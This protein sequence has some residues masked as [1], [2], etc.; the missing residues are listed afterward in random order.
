MV[1]VTWVFH[2]FTPLL[3][4]PFIQPFIHLYGGHGVNTPG[5]AW[6]RG[7]WRVRQC[8]RCRGTA[9]CCGFG[10]G[11]AGEGQRCGTSADAGQELLCKSEFHNSGDRM[12]R[13]P[14]PL[15]G[16]QLHQGPPQARHA[17]TPTRKHMPSSCH[18]I[19][20]FLSLLPLPLCHSLPESPHRTLPEPS[21]AASGHEISWTNAHPS[22]VNPKLL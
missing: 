7:A 3:V 15:T 22:E 20:T 13:Q 2:S 8:H 9:L 11:D 16:R 1:K 6:G 4:H 19:Y 12:H 18:T 14:P 21:Q 17:V 5:Q 10:W